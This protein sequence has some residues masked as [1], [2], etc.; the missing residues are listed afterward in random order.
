VDG[1]ALGSGLTSIQTS[2]CLKNEGIKGGSN[3]AKVVSPIGAIF[4]S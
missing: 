1:L 3:R 2:L 4:I